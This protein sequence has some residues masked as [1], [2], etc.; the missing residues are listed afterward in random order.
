M[1]PQLA[2]ASSGMRS[3]FLETAWHCS[4]RYRGVRRHT[5]IHLHARNVVPRVLADQPEGKSRLPSVL[6]AETHTWLGRSLAFRQAGANLAARNESADE[7]ERLGAVPPLARVTK[8][9]ALGEKCLRR[10]QR[11]TGGAWLFRCRS[12]HAARDTSPSNASRSDRACHSHRLALRHSPS[13]R[14]RKCSGRTMQIM[15][16]TLKF[17]LFFS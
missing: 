5:H 3:T 11:R 16:E 9:Q 6:R 7:K 1:S 13:Q 14:V 15:L 2:P 8:Y 4:K 10:T 12:C 17:V